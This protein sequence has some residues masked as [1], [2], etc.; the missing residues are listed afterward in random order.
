MNSDSLAH[1]IQDPLPGTL[2]WTK[3]RPFESSALMLVLACQTSTASVL[4]VPLSAFSDGGEQGLDAALSQVQPQ[5]LAVVSP[6]RLGLPI[7]RLTP[8][9]YEDVRDRLRG[10]LTRGAA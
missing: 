2:C 5:T 6:R 4:E 3:E 1:P 9:Q 10:W 8:Q 7:G